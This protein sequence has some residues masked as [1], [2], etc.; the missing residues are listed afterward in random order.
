[1]E[2]AIPILAIGGMYVISNQQKKNTQNQNQTQSQSQGQESFDNMGLLGQNKRL[3]NTDIS[4]VNYPSR[5]STDLGGNQVS[6]YENPNQATST[7]LNQNLYENRVNQGD[8]V[9]AEIQDIYS[10]SG[11]YQNSESF[12][13]NNMVP[14]YGGKI[15]GFTYDTQI[16][17][18]RLDNMSGSGSQNIKKVEQAPL[19]KPE[20]NMNWAFG[21][22]N[23]S[24][25]YQS[26]VNPGMKNNNVKPFDSERVGPGLGQGFTT[27]GSGGFNSGMESRDAWLPKTVD[28]LRVATNPRLEYSLESHEGPADSYIKNL[29]Q[30]GRVEKNRPDRFYLQ[31]QDRWL[32][33]TGSEKGE[34][35]RPIQEMGVIRRPNEDVQYT[36][37]AGTGVRSANYVAPGFEQPKREE[38]ISCDVPHSNARGKGP[39]L[40]EEALIRTYNNYNNHRSTS[41]QPDS[42]RSGFSRAVGAVVAPLMDIMK[43]SRKEEVVQNL[44]V[45]G[46]ASGRVPY[47]YVI[48]PKDTAPPTIKQS[49]LYAPAFNMQNQ[50]GEYVNNNTPLNIQQ[51]QSTEKEYIGS[52]GGHGTQYGDMDYSY[53]YRQTNNDTKSSTVNGRT[54]VGNMSVFSGQQ[55]LSYC[56]PDTN[57]MDNRFFT[58]GSV[59]PL[60]P[61][62]EN[63]GTMHFPIENNVA[64]TRIEPGILEQFRQNPYTHS[65]VDSV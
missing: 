20:D 47:N 8:R 52:S 19:F 58:P 2:L 57:C 61:A 64:C 49:T 62:K 35:L 24:D 54:E 15:K 63:Y 39:S 34:T 55:N 6:A 36:G 40:E 31:G 42:F 22:P 7:Y 10:L 56:R 51:R 48:N 12:K 32:T 29:G 53:M 46:E 65:L 33:T 43:P 44:R 18:S 45:F 21:A 5:D 30:I 17:E 26:R 11:N 9:Q 4:P 59:I 16:A 37:V 25:F 60:P 1:M 28:Q 38:L 3:P 13:H 23:Q 14:F 41:D 27:S 50:K